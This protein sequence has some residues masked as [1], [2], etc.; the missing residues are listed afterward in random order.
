MTRQDRN[1]TSLF[2]KVSDVLLF[3]GGFTLGVVLNNLKEYYPLNPQLASLS[4]SAISSSL[5]SNI[6]SQM[7][8]PDVTLAVKNSNPKL[9]IVTAAPTAS[10]SNTSQTFAF[11]IR[12]NNMSKICVT[13]PNITR[14]YLKKYLRPPKAFRDMNVSELLWRASMSPRIPEYPIHLVPKVAF[15]FL[16]KGPVH[17]ALLW[18]N[19]FKGHQGLYS[20]YVHSSPSYEAASHPE[21]TTFVTTILL[22]F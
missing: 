15:M 6:P 16:T 14:G 9:E 1:P 17:L 3:V 19:F 8:M 12:S 11:Q 22:S 20:I 2:T 10:N 4:I 18:E 7:L 5:P 21:C 13:Q